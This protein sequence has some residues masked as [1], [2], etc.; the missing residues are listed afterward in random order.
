MLVDGDGGGGNEALAGD[1]GVAVCD[2][3]VVVVVGA[4][5]VAGLTT[6]G[7]PYGG[8]MNRR[9][10]SGPFN[11]TAAEAGDEESVVGVRALEA[12]SDDARLVGQLFRLDI[13]IVLLSFVNF[14]ESLLAI[15]SL[16]VKVRLAPFAAA[17]VVATAVAAAAAADSAAALVAVSTIDQIRGLQ[18][19]EASDVVF[20]ALD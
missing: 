19:I 5:P 16:V 15:M 10:P 17:I 1:E 12:L 18:S 2:E 11:S 8:V 13:A 20:V 4:T 3:T 14:F 6:V 7:L 9:G